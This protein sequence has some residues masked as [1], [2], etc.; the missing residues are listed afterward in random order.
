M[1]AVGA[2]RTDSHNFREMTALLVELGAQG[3]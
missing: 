2:K 3:F 1:V